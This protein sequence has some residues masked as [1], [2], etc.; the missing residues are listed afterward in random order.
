MTE[1]EAR[2][3]CEDRFS[4]TQV[5]R[6]G[7]F[8]GLILE[9]NSHQNL[10]SP[11]TCATI[12]S[13][14]IVDSAQLVGFVP[15]VAKSLADVG[16]GPGLPG[17]VVAILTDLNVTLIEPRARRAA[18]LRQAAEH[19]HLTNV[20]VEQAKAEAVGGTFDVVSARAVANIAKIITMTAHLRH[21]TSRLILPRGAGGQSEVD[22]LPPKLT[23]MFHV[24]QSVTDGR[25]VIV[26]AEGV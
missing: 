5:E 23:Q 10:I 18:F 15:Q 19:L 20:R 25:S 7:R 9:E 26:V 13:R 11:A 3:Y 4:A 17:L 14:H 12:W 2:A 22:A 6:L 1:D 21:A 16:S 24:E 8:V